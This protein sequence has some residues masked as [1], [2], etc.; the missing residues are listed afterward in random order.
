[1]LF[2]DS[3]S[4]VV[5]KHADFRSSYFLSVQLADVSGGLFTEFEDLISAAI[6]IIRDDNEII[7][8]LY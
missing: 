6:A 2:Y 7:T 5:A 8:I 4:E 1:M 3:D